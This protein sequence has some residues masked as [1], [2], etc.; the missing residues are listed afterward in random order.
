MRNQLMGPR[1]GEVGGWFLVTDPVDTT[2]HDKTT[3]LNTQRHIP[4]ET[5]WFT[6]SHL[7]HPDVFFSLDVTMVKKNCFLTR[8]T[9]D[10]TS[11]NTKCTGSGIQHPDQGPRTGIVTTRIIFMHLCKSEVL[12]LHFIAFLQIIHIA[13]KVKAAQ[14]FSSSL[15]SCHCYELAGPGTT[16]SGCSL[17]PRSHAS[18]S[19]H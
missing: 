12:P 2:P 8:R 4:Q 15:P 5:S 7:I 17:A 19:S 18:N 13:E 1:G 10:W 16:E 6:V 11:G 14:R 3:T 9:V